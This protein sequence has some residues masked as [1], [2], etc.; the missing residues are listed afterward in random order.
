[1]GVPT[2]DHPPSPADPAAIERINELSRLARTNWFTLLAYLAFVGVSLLAVEDADF[3]VPSRQTDLPLIGV[4]IPTARF[5]L[6]A[7]LLGAALYVYLH[8]HLTKLWEALA[9]ARRAHGGDALAH[10]VYPW[11]V[12]RLGSDPAGRGAGVTEASVNSIQHRDAPA[13]LGG[14]PRDPILVLVALDA[15]A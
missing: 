15:R 9:A 13:G 8:I 11:L 2:P 7:P 5:F 14:R 4:S 10:R 3:F 12:K 6:A 1:M